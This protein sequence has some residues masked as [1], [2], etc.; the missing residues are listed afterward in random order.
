MAVAASQGNLPLCVLLWGMAT[1]KKVNLLVPDV[2]GNTPFHFAALAD[3]PEVLG[4]LQQ[5]DRSRSS[6]NPANRLV[7]ARNNA[8]ETPLLRAASMGKIP[9]L[10][11]LLDEGSDPFA[12]DLQG[13]TIFI[14][15]ARCG[16][17]WGLHFV[18][19]AIQDGYGPRV[20]FELISTTDRDNRTALDWAADLGDVNIVEYLIRKNL[21]PNRK[22]AVGRT[23]LHAA[24]KS[25][26]V[27]ATR[28]L[29]KCGC[30]PS[31]PDFNKETAKAIAYASRNGD[32]IAAINVR[33]ARLDPSTIP[34]SGS[35][36]AGGRQNGSCCARPCRRRADKNR[37]RLELDDGSLIGIRGRDLES[38]IGMLSQR[39]GGVPIGDSGRTPTAN[40]FDMGF[41]TQQ[42]FDLPPA[43]TPN[44][45]LLS[46]TSC[47]DVRPHAICRTK[48]SRPIYALAYA[49]I[50]VGY[51]M[52][53]ACI[54]FYAWL[55]LVGLTVALFRIS[56]SQ[57]K[58]VEIGPSD[59]CQSFFHN[60]LTAR[61]KFLGV[62]GGMLVTC[63]LFWLCSLRV[64]VLYDFR[65]SAA[66]LYEMTSVSYTTPTTGVE[67]LV[68][69]GLS[70]STDDFGLFVASLVA[71][72][73]STALWSKLVWFDTDPGVVYTRHQDFEVI[74]EE[75]LRTGGT[76]APEKYCRTTLVKKPLR[77]K[78]CSQTGTVIARMDHFC[79]WLNNSVGHGNHR[80]FI[81]FLV[82]QLVA[83][84]LF[85]VM[86]IRAVHRELGFSPSACV[87]VTNLL[88]EEYFFA[89]A[90]TAFLCLASLALGALLAEQAVNIARNITT[91]ERLNGSRYPWMND[92]QGQPFNH[93]DRGMLV[94]IL[95]F[96]CVPGFR[97]DY[98][99]E[100]E[101]PHAAAETKTA[102]G[103]DG[104]T[105]SNVF[106]ASRTDSEPNIPHVGGSRDDL[107]SGVNPSPNAAIFSRSR[108]SPTNA[109]TAGQRSAAQYHLQSSIP[110]SRLPS[111]RMNGE[112]YAVAKAQVVSSTSPTD[113]RARS[114]LGSSSNNPVAARRQTT[115]NRSSLPQIDQRHVAVGMGQT[116]YPSAHGVTGAPGGPGAVPSVA[117][118]DPT[119]PFHGA[120]NPHQ[121]PILT[122]TMEAQAQLEARVQQAIG[123]SMSKSSMRLAFADERGLNPK[124]VLAAPPGAAPPGAAPPSE[125]LTAPPGASMS[126]RYVVGPEATGLQQADQNVIAGAR[127]HAHVHAHA[128]QKPP[129]GMH[130]MSR[131]TGGQGV[132]ADG[133]YSSAAPADRPPP[134]AALSAGGKR[135]A[136]PS[137]RQGRGEVKWGNVDS[138]EASS[139][140]SSQES[141]NNAMFAYDSSVHAGNSVA[142]RS[143]NNSIEGLVY[144]DEHTSEDYRTKSQSH[145]QSQSVS[146][147]GSFDFFQPPSFRCASSEGALP[148]VT[149]NPNPNASLLSL[150][151]SPI[152]DTIPPPMGSGPP[153][154]HAA[155]LARRSS[156]T[157]VGAGGGTGGG[158]GG[159]F[160]SLPEPVVV[161]VVSTHREGKRVNPVFST[162]KRVEWDGHAPPPS[163]VPS[164]ARTALAA[165]EATS[166]ELPTSS[167]DQQLTTLGAKLNGTELRPRSGSV[168]GS[169]VYS[170]SGSFHKVL[171]P[172]SSLTASQA[173][174]RPRPSQS[175][176]PTLPGPLPLPLPLTLPEGAMGMAMKESKAGEGES[177]GDGRL[178]WTASDKQPTVRL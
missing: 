147:R 96:W 19:S 79:V 28:F 100:F 152:P 118:S 135:G 141:R 66:Y 88:D 171:P 124:S 97:R 86:L 140:G 107:I 125:D 59:G 119:A 111:Y 169:S 61:E 4:F 149:L 128:Q 161:S 75:C 62:Y 36:S 159:V 73:V 87:A 138:R 117:V 176:S 10:K 172:L 35:S 65:S 126:S 132:V 89:T 56:G 178:G 60:F 82:S 120:S 146:G 1:A 6:T 116:S 158:A 27:E 157:D 45:S 70:A 21:D 71:L 104:T 99:T 108:S 25:G 9:I 46:S 113:R 166:G 68:V 148:R 106:G 90:L 18:Y 12:T 136:S 114:V 23:A 63:L 7:D 133:Y 3:V 151:A 142:S 58:R 165:S 143:G 17:L 13:N 15:L 11:Y 39:P 102:P 14:I 30:D 81:M 41:P 69:G 177:E 26:R 50:V 170:D 112:V 127:G 43:V 54:P 115:P 91:N 47:G 20:T 94:N 92:S 85:A 109:G 64:G 53:S 121:T 40:D 167:S 77:S 8:G 74:L 154:G 33:S 139:E 57:T 130:G 29:V 174:P 38:G 93:F 95:E 67:F 37:D 122:R 131:S 84:T 55:L 34:S 101:L 72:I 150:P 83:T 31:R 80:S 137:T 164:P 24:V 163:N 145:P 42:S 123:L 162:Y 134:H 153:L 103:G 5:Q 98:F 51:W 52:L 110:Q 168:A 48:P 175:P 2:Q 32:L 49:T 76:P 16:H 78:Y 44:V 144:D 129:R 155:G 22:D 173:R 160:P 156:G 105:S